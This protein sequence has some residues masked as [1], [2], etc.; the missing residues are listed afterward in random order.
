MGLPKTI[1]DAK[2]NLETSIAYIPDRYRKSVERASWAEAAASKQAESNFATQMSV[3]IAEGKRAKGCA[4]AGD[5]K[6][7]EGAMTKGAPVIGARIRASL[8]VYSKN[9]GV[10][11]AAVLAE[12]PRL[13]ARTLDPMTNIDNRLKRVVDVFIKNKVR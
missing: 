10:P 7:R 8:D 5:A 3:V 6:W 1:E 13:P 12:L 9:F 4:L 11:Y 2:A